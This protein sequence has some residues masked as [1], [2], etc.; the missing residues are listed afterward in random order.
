MRRIV[1]LFASTT[2]HADAVDVPEAVCPTIASVVPEPFG[3]LTPSV[4]IVASVPVAS[5]GTM[6]DGHKHDVRRRPDWQGA[7]TNTIRS[8][9]S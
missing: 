3:A 6:G 9:M 5:H 1:S 4:A 2:E 8:T 7:Q